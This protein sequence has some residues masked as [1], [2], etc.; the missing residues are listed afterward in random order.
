M[1]NRPGDAAT[2]HG[3][4]IILM[5]GKQTYEKPAQDCGD[6]EREQLQRGGKV[7]TVV[8]EFVGV[9]FFFLPGSITARFQSQNKLLVSKKIKN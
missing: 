8:S 4:K 7:V 2:D 1:V 6:L 3:R 9:F 5:N